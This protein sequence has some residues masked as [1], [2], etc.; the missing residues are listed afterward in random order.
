MKAFPFSICFGI[1][2]TVSL[3]PP[4]SALIL[5]ECRSYFF[6][7]S[8]D[9]T[10]RRPYFGIEAPSFSVRPWTQVNQFSWQLRGFHFST[11]SEGFLLAVSNCWRSFHILCLKSPKRSR[12]DGKPETE[13]RPAEPELE[14]DRMD[15]DH[16]QHRRLQDPLPLEAVSKGVSASINKHSSD[17]SKVPLS[18]SYFQVLRFVTHNV[19]EFVNFVL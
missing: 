14:N 12:R 7:F 13:R 6:Y 1:N 10:P 4:P 17:P 11:F 16:R 8:P 3:Q 9:V 18:R 5:I 15:R 2:C 19:V